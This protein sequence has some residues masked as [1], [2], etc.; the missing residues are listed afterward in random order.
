MTDFLHRFRRRLQEHANRTGDE[1]Y[2]GAAAVLDVVIARRR[3]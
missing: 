1:R 2:A 3:G